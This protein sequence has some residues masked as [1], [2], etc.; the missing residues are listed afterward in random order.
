MFSK[1]ETAESRPK[2]NREEAVRPAALGGGRGKI[3]RS[4]MARPVLQIKKP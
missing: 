3:F 2:G 1:S 4:A